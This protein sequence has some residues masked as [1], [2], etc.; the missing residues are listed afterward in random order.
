MHYVLRDSLK[1]TYYCF[2]YIVV[3]QHACLIKHP[4]LGRTHNAMYQP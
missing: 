3:G 2:S 1:R 4:K